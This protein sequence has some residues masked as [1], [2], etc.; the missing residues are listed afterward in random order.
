MI[1]KSRLYGLA[2]NLKAVCMGWRR[3]YAKA[4]INTPNNFCNPHNWCLW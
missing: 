1:N 2:Q 3:I 4:R